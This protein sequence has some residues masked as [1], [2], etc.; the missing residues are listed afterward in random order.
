MV[1]AGR[2]RVAELRGGTRDLLRRYRET[3]DPV[4]R[5]RL[6]ELHLPLV[7]V[8]ARRYANRGERLEDLVQVGSI[9]LIEAIDRF[10]PERGR[11]FVSFAVP[12]ISGEIKNHLRDRAA[13]VRIPR[14]VGELNV[15]LRAESDTL[16]ARLRRP[17][18]LA[19]LARETGVGEVE[20][21]E[22]I[23]TERARVPVPL[24]SGNGTGESE[25]AILVDDAFESSDDRLLL[26]AG[27]RALDARQRRIMHLRFFGGL[28]QAE[29]AREV[30][31]SQIHVSRLIRTSLERMRGALGRE[32]PSMQAE[33][34]LVRI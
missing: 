1:D 4:V 16:A 5:E 23:A 29:I 20:V 9:G 14:R 15:R 7:R 31:L 11:D 17:P 19:E 13:V 33:R 28:S 10:D 25:D 18:T 21:S 8:L 22:A 27:F 3:G 32:H 12:T 34:P 6:V 26:A 30:G 2:N 24:P